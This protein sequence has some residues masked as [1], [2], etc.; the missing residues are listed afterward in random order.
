MKDREIGLTLVG[1]KNFKQVEIDN[2]VKTFS[3]AMNNKDFKINLLQ[4]LFDSQQYLVQY[5]KQ[6]GLSKTISKNALDR[7]FEINF[8]IKSIIKNY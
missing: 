7:A 2:A 5:A 1:L 3:M 4:R 8:L 6:P